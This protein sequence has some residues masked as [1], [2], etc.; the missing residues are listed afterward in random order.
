MH[1]R[2]AVTVGKCGLAGVT[3]NLFG[4]YVCNNKEVESGFEKPKISFGFQL[5][6]VAVL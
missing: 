4:I 2:K 3:S 1:L 6:S 5:W